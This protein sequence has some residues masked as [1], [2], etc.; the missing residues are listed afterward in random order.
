MKQRRKTVTRGV[1]KVGYRTAAWSD[2]P[3]CAPIERWANQLYRTL[4]EVDHSNDD[5]RLA[6]IAGL[7]VHDY[8][9]NIEAL[10]GLIAA[11]LDV[12]F[13][14][15]DP[16]HDS[17]PE[18]DLH[19]ESRRIAGVL[20]LQPGSWQEAEEGLGTPRA[21]TAAGRIR[22]LLERNFESPEFVIVSSCEE[23]ESVCPRL[24]RLTSFSR[25]FELAAP[26]PEELGGVFVTSCDR[27][28]LSPEVRDNPRRVGLLLKG[29]YDGFEGRALARLFVQRIAQLEHR[30]VTLKDLALLD[31]VGVVESCRTLPHDYGFA[32]RVA[33]H[34]AGHVVVALADSLGSHIPEYVTIIPRRNTLGYM[35]LSSEH[36]ERCQLAYTRKMMIHDLRVLLAGRAAE[37]LI[38]G[39]SEVS[40]LSAHDLERAANLLRTG[41]LKYGL[42][43]ASSMAVLP[44]LCDTS[45]AGG[46]VFAQVASLPAWRHYLEREYRIARKIA[47]H[48]RSLLE[49]IQQRLIGER[50]LFC[51]DL[52]A[53]WHSYTESEQHQCP[54]AA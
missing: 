8:P 37:A 34:E 32:E 54:V 25:I 4:K 44:Q 49:L 9:R 41:V 15:I 24:R 43:F 53:M 36:R 52:E 48:N 3:G 27:E 33:W 14:S 40:D 21:D 47:E 18:I 23:A 39:D 19:N 45:F 28:W 42:Q 11:K 30:K 6:G 31:S 2:L 13:T 22:M 7:V 46:G 50:V 1:V 16:E 17:L 51:D 26:S 10:S 38:Y 5:L 12:P 20:F 35:T 29:C